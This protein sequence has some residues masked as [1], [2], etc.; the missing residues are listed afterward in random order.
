MQVKRK[1][2]SLALLPLGL[3]LLGSC[4]APTAENSAVIDHGSVG[5]D[6]PT[7]TT[8]SMPKPVTS[9]ESKTSAKSDIAHL[10]SSLN[11]SL[12][13]LAS[14]VDYP[15]AVQIEDATRKVASDQQ[16]IEISPVATPTGL[17]ADSIQVAF[18]T[19]SK[20]CI[21]GYIRGNNVSTSALP[22]LPNGKCMV[23]VT[24]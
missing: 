23:G 3:I 11:Q 5:T 9:Q 6:S 22:V 10:E 17:R 20:D 1:L 19:D 14:S 12:K 16:K 21:F 15:S 7:P 4:S 2:A 13:S 18:V 8:S 24:S